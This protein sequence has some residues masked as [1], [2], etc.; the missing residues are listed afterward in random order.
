MGW[1]IPIL[2]DFLDVIWRFLKAIWRFLEAI[3]GF[4]T[5]H[6]VTLVSTASSEQA[7]PEQIVDNVF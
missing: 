5:K 2:G 6:L 1:A 4:F 7:A 3:E